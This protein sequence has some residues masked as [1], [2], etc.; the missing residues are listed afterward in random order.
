MDA[1]KLYSSENSCDEIKISSNVS[2]VSVKSTYRPKFSLSGEEKEK[3]LLEGKIKLLDGSELKCYSLPQTM[4]EVDNTMRLDTTGTYLI[5]GRNNA[6]KHV[7]TEKEKNAEIMAGAAEKQLFLEN[8]FFLLA[9]SKRI[10]SDSRMFLCPVPI[11]NGL[12]YTGTSGFHCPTLGV[13]IEWWMNCGASMVANKKGAKWLVY[14]IA[15]SPLS[16]S[17]SCGVVNEQGETTSW[18][19]VPFKDLWTSFIEINSRYDYAKNNYE[20][21][22]LKQVL[23]L[24]GTDCDYNAVHILFLENRN[25]DLTFQVSSLRNQVLDMT[26]KLHKALMELKTCELRNFIEAY[27]KLKDETDKHVSDIR[28]E[29]IRLRKLLRSNAIGNVE[30]QK[31]WS[32][33][34]RAKESAIYKFQNFVYSSLLSIFPEER[35]TLDEV[36]EFLEENDNDGKNVNY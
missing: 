21:Y 25:K 7:K 2:Y 10:L 5:I 8:A 34:R 17:N 6:K 3:A 13:Y 18:Q 24:L 15:G 14:H 4:P 23:D 36:K 35:I 28:E 22:S 29:R 11:Q 27:N 20:A 26:A 30:Y 16:G 12:A 32:P 1:K 19:I 9:N 31:N 33:L